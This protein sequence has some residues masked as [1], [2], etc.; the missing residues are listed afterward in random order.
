MWENHRR[1][2]VERERGKRHN[3][4]NEKG[5]MPNANCHLPTSSIR[6]P[7]KPLRPPPFPSP[8]SPHPPSFPWKGS[9]FFLLCMW[10]LLLFFRLPT[11]PYSTP[12]S[13]T[14]CILLLIP[15]WIMGINNKTLIKKYGVVSHTSGKTVL[16]N[17]AVAVWGLG[18]WHS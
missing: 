12:N 18:R 9:F 1:G 17:V 5:K 16:S 2:W 4:E 13:C 15:L 14:T 11:Y 6:H 3:K 7:C 10:L 8:L